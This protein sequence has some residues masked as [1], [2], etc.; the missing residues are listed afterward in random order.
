MRDESITFQSW[1]CTCF[2]PVI[3]QVLMHTY[4]L[5]YWVTFL[6]PL[7]KLKW[8]V[9]KNN[10][11]LFLSLILKIL[12]SDGTFSIGAW[13]MTERYSLIS[14]L[15]FVGQ[16]VTHL[17]KCTQCNAQEPG[18]K[19][20]V[21]TFLPPLWISVCSKHTKKENLKILFNLVYDMRQ[22]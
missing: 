7:Y 21:P 5:F 20:V 19:P 15:S 3:M 22:Y 16:V 17:V 1:C 11:T 4:M 10:G 8:A 2:Y 6:A 12:L 14:K 13:W 18:V 9:K